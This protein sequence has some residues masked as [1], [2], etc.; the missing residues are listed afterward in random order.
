M[1]AK[2]REIDVPPGSELAQAI[3]E[4]FGAPIVVV[5][6]GVRYRLE[7]EDGASLNDS[8]RPLIGVADE[9]DQAVLDKIIGAWAGL[10]TDRLKEELRLAR[11]EGSRS[12]GRP[13]SSS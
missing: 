11:E 3:D 6:D 9:D 10:D 5:K 13:G 2:A 1:V 7:R 12:V 8:D 4:S